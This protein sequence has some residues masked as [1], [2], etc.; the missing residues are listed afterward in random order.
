MRATIDGIR[1]HCELRV[2]LCSSR[3]LGRWRGYVDEMF[4][5]GAAPTGQPGHKKFNSRPVA[6]TFFELSPSARTS[7]GCFI[8]VDERCPVWNAIQETVLHPA[9]Q[10]LR[11]T[12]RTAVT[13]PVGQ[14]R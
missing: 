2:T 6:P 12:P 1:P 13:P 9:R 3:A 8:L 11:P 10:C 7:K 4:S 14:P 5:C